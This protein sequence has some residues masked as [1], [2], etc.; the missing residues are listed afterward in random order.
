[1]LEQEFWWE[2]FENI[3]HNWQVNLIQE[4]N[5]IHNLKYYHKNQI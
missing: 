5:D 4:L 3:L 2:T 1:M